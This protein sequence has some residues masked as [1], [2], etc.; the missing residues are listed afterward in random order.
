MI[1]SLCIQLSTCGCDG[2][3]AGP[4]KLELHDNAGKIIATVQLDGPI[5]GSASW[6][7]KFAEPI[8]ADS[9]REAVLIND[10]DDSATLTW[11]SVTGMGE[12]GWSY[13]FFD[14]KCKGVTIGK[15][16]CPRFVMF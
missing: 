10:T 5:D 3:T 2:G 12:C 11:F 7:Y 13:N 15:D 6:N 8:K 16:G 1:D 14:K 9:L 4:L